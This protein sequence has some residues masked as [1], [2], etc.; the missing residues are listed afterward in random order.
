MSLSARSLR[1]RSVPSVASGEVTSY[2]E[3]CRTAGNLGRALG[4]VTRMSHFTADLVVALFYGA[5]AFVVVTGW[6]RWARQSQPRNTFSRFALIGFALA[7]VSLIIAVAGIVYARKIGG[8]SYYDPRLMRLFRW[9]GL[10]SLGGF[11]FSAVGVWRRSALRWY[12]VA[13]SL[14]TLFFW[15]ASAMSE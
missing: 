6:V 3:R 12:A 4:R 10:F 11:L 2:P 8:F 5:T 7:N 15:F 13:L 14:L 1:L 9:G